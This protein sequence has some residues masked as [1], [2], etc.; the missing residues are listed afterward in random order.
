MNH[1]ELLQHIRN[2]PDFPKPG[3]EFK[4]ITPIFS[5]PTLCK[6]LTDEF[7]NSFAHTK[8]DAVAGIEA[9]G[10]LFGFMIAQQ[11]GLP[12]I[13]I[14]KAGKLPYHKISREY[15]LEYGMAKIEMHVD[16]IRPG[17]HILLHDDL[18]A[19]GGS[20]EAAA[21]LIIEAGGQLAGFAFLVNLSF[22]D[23]ENR[24]QKFDVPVKSIVH[25]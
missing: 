11:L 25:F 3:I 21:E 8:I 14:R 16:A 23:G 4:D 1:T 20:A 24:L 12:F 2:I 9:R 6:D 19:T 22:L 13:P 18:L 10:F 17:N 15:A 5:N 7:V